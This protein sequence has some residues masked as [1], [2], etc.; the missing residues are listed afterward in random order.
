[1]CWSDA[2]NHF[3]GF[4]WCPNGD[5]QSGMGGGDVD[6]NQKEKVI[7]QRENDRK[8]NKIKD[9]QTAIYNTFTCMK[10]RPTPYIIYIQK[11]EERPSQSV[12]CSSRSGNTVQ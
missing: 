9:T 1:V 8:I 4:V 12:D 3:A 11:H 10:K 7:A 2:D 6:V 5:L